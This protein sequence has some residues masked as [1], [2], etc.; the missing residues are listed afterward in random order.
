MRNVQFLCDR[1]RG[2]ARGRTEE[3]REVE[4]RGTHEFKFNKASPASAAQ[5]LSLLADPNAA[6]IQ[7]EDIL[8]LHPLAAAAA[9]S[10]NNDINHH[11][12]F[13]GSISISSPSRPCPTDWK[14]RLRFRP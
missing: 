14:L 13:T 4:G 10:M 6:A 8:I 11:P 1:S 5:V 7:L 9:V 3:G 2:W 12:R